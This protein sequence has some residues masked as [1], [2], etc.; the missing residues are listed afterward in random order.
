MKKSLSL[1]VAIAMVFS[2]FAT[3][4]AAATDTQSKYNELKE[5]GVFRGT[6]DGSAALENEMT[7][8]EFAGIIARLTGVTSS[9]T[10]KFNDVPSSHW[11]SKDIA[12][13]AEAGYMEGTGNNNFAPSKNVTLQELIKVAV[14]IV[15]L[16]IDEDA[17][18][19]GKADAWAQPYIAAAIAAGLIQPLDDYTVNATRGD[20]VD[21]TYEVYQVLQNI[22]KVTGYEVVS[23]TKVVVSFSDGGEVEVELD[24]PL[25]LGKNTI[26]VTYN[27]REYKVEVEFEAVAA[28]AKA[29]GAKKIEVTFNQAVDDSKAKFAVKN[30]I[31]DRVVDKAVFSD[32]KKKAVL[33]LTT[34]LQAGETTVTISGIDKDD[35]VAKFT[36]EDEKITQVKFKSDKLALSTNT[37]G[38]PKYTEAK[39]AYQILNQY[40]EEA[41]N[42]GTPTFQIG[43][44]TT[45]VSATNGVL[46]IEVPTTSPF[47]LGEKVII[48][49]YLR[50][51]T[52]GVT[53]SETL[54]VG[55]P[56]TVDSVEVVGLYHPDNKELNTS[57]TFS[58]YVLLLEVKDQYGNK[59]DASKFNSGA[60]V[61]VS[62]PGIFNVNTTATDNNGPNKDQV[63]LQ[64][65]A[66]AFTPGFDGT[67]T[68]RIMTLSGKQYSYDVEVKKAATVQ[69][70]TLMAPSQVVAANDGTVKIPFVAEDQFGNEIK[71]YSD[72]EGK[73]VLSPAPT[74]SN[75]AG[76][77]LKQDYVT[78]EAYIELT[79]PTPD[80]NQQIAI[81]YP[82]MAYVSGTPNTSQIVINI[83]KPAY[84]ESISGL[85]SDVAAT[86]ATNATTTIKPDYIKVKDNYGRDKKLADLLSDGTHKVVVSVADNNPD[87]VSL[88]ATELTNANDSITVTALQKGNERIKVQLVKTDDNTVVYSYESFVFSVVDNSGIAE[89]AIEQVP[90]LSN[91][92]NRQVELKV[93]GK[94]SNGSTV[95]LPIG[96]YTA[97]ASNGVVVTADGKIDASGFNGAFTDG[98]GKAVLKVTI[99]ATSETLEQELVI[100]NAALAVT[101]FELENA[102]GLEAKDLVVKGSVAALTANGGDVVRNV[103]GT[104]KVKDQFGFKMS[105][106]EGADLSDFNV[107]V[108]NPDNVAGTD[109]TYTNNGQSGDTV[110]I[111]GIDQGDSFSLIFVSKVSGASITLRVVAE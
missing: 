19:D 110:T 39:V 90:K 13:V 44:P 60:F 111:S 103:F 94:R 100:S 108:A 95:A 85:T 12:A 76:L 45:N 93:V 86:L 50:L 78:K 20:L 101:S 102:N 32:D 49:G 67:N 52:Y 21:V 58:D 79:L 69:K 42:V 66:P 33:E 47:Y 74:A 22:A 24:E 2:M 25:K 77:R 23:A 65:A 70:I 98:E 4:A 80:P 71:K 51:S 55:Q 84:P 96:S 109:I 31:A 106:A 61:T 105:A 18:V 62:N 56:A 28:S 89:Y 26:T 104:L 7:R 73:I 87:V 11:A 36:A 92:P 10:A 5:A 83:E 97:T 40:G 35:V 17:T 54:E 15:G 75:S 9:G 107:T 59:L 8:A 88:S 29:V 81:P 14:T 63:G 6:G 38:S 3:V 46:T 1:L 48:T 27:D 99:V 34:K 68:I 82:I 57:S 43:K 64:L 91:K 16:E 53:I 72:L 41:S 30:G 37:D